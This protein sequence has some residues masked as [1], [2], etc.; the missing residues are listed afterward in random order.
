MDFLYSLTEKQEKEKPKKHLL[1][2]V[3]QGNKDPAM[4]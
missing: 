2:M 4:N 1:H 3:Q